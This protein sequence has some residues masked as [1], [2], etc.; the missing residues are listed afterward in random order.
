[1]A[2]HGWMCQHTLVSTWRGRVGASSA[3]QLQ[4]KTAAL[5]CCYR[6][7]AVAE[8]AAGG[9]TAAASAAASLLRPQTGSTV[10]DTINNP[11]TLYAQLLTAQRECHC[12]EGPGAP[13]EPLHAPQTDNPGICSA[14]VLQRS[15][16]T[17]RQT[18]FNYWHHQ[19]SCWLM[20]GLLFECCSRLLLKQGCNTSKQLSSTHR[21]NHA[22]MPPLQRP[23]STT[24]AAHHKA[25]RPAA[26]G[27]TGARP[28]L[29]LLPL[30]P[31]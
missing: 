3:L 19:F 20:Q 5:L 31:A 9:A 8:P 30:A 22:C 10:Q 13:G 1:M 23:S 26:A 6:G 14:L 27:G 15:C 25:A 17:C 18:Q 12:T 29:C 28:T 2:V 4:A 21:C 24:K 11:T 16:V 7:L